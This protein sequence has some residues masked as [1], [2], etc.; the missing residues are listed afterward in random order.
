[1]L[2]HHIG[3]FV[4]GII[5]SVHVLFAHIVGWV[6]AVSVF[7][8]AALPAIRVF[9][10]LSVFVLNPPRFCSSPS[11]CMQL[12]S[13]TPCYLV[14]YLVLFWE[15][16]TGDTLKG[17]RTRLDDIHNPDTAHHC[18]IAWV[19][20]RRQATTTTPTHILNRHFLL[21]SSPINVVFFGN[22]INSDSFFLGHGLA[23]RIRIIF[24]NLFIGLRQQSVYCYALCMCTSGDALTIM[25]MWC[26]IHIFCGIF[27][28]NVL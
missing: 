5:N 28:V 3:V 7:F 14:N 22:R 15:H 6:V 9:F 24:R 12:S 26:N 13:S 20:R 18:H 8:F 10:F 11:Q 4:F 21:S 17:F 25:M 2:L 1:M 27:G 16:S 23:S 19:L